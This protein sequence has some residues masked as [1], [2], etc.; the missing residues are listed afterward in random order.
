MSCY[1]TIENVV[2]QMIA[3]AQALQQLAQAIGG[4]G[5]VQQISTSMNMNK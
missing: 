2:D 4:E 1:E 3:A 5:G